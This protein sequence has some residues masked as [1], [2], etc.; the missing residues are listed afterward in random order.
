MLGRQ[1]CGY[2][3]LRICSVS[4]GVGCDQSFLLWLLTGDWSG[5]AER[6]GPRQAPICWSV[7]RSSRGWAMSSPDCAGKQEGGH[8]RP[9]APGTR[10]PLRAPSRACSSY[11]ATCTRSTSWPPTG[12]SRQP[13]RPP[14]LAKPGRPQSRSRDLLSGP[15]QAAGSAEPPGRPSSTPQGDR[16]RRPAELIRRSFSD[17][18]REA[19]TEW[20]PI[21]QNFCKKRRSY[22]ACDRQAGCRR[23]R[24]PRV[25]QAVS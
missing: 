21:R 4:A 14:D 17:R 8:A 9:L 13:T 10:C 1:G 25:P 24:V 22:G 6:S 16:G 7:R 19:R 20:I 18:Q 3:P 5:A 15:R 11:A 23:C 12:S 2:A